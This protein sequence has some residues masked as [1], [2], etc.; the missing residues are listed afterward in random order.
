[1]KINFLLLIL[2]II[3]FP[4]SID[5]LQSEVPSLQEVL[6]IA[7]EAD[8]CELEQSY[9]KAL[10]LYKDAVEKLLPVIESKTDSR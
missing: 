3:H 4:I 6:Q 5:E 7:R 10:E 9:K 2:F 1:M 8:K